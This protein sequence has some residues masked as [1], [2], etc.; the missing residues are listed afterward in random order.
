[1]AFL[2]SNNR[3]HLHHLCWWSLHT[4]LSGHIMHVR[5]DM[6]ENCLVARTQVIMPALAHFMYPVLRATA[7][8]GKSPLT[9]H[10]L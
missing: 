7:M 1:M 3:G 5:V 4:D 6:T 2:I 10:A 8:T 9:A